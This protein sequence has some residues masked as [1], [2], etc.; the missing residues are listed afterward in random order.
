MSFLLAEQNTN[1]ALRYA[2]YG[3]ILE[4]GRVVMD[5]EADGAARERG[6]EGVLSRRRRRRPQEL[7][8][9][10][11]LQAPQALAGVTPLAAMRARP[12]NCRPTLRHG[13]PPSLPEPDMTDHLDALETR[14]P[15]QREADLFAR[16]P[17]VLARALAA[18]GWA[19][20]LG[21][22]RPRGHHRRARRSRG[23]RCC[24]SPNLPAMQK[25]RSAL[26]RLRRRR[27]SRPSAG[28]SR[29]RGRSSSRRA[30]HADPWGTARALF[31]AG[32]RAGDIVLNTFCYH[33]TPGGFI[34][35]CGAR[36]LGCAVIPAGPG[37]HRAA[38]GRHRAPAAGRPM[39]ARPTS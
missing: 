10:E 17:Q 4:T 34:M 39:P 14:S 37:Q 29:R 35:D 33:L 23:C 24:A 1:M 5:G 36:A 16:L 19:K 26:R 2:T 6:R 30:R 11:E 9:R 27:R 25:A 7:P 32:F 18:P 21:R 3:Y 8:R 15:A 22:H 38:A 31:A 13:P 20:H 12:A 28:C